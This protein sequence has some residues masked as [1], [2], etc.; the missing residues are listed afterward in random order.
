MKTS[1]RPPTL[2]AGLA[3]TVA[4][5]LC[6]GTAAAAGKRVGVPKFDGPQEALVRKRV[7]QV[8]K[9]EGYELVKSRELEAAAQSTGQSLDS[10]DAFR[11]VAKELALSAFVTG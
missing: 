2:F 7:M 4:L 6:A 5:L 11:A 10:N 9:S 3:L 1:M 8:L